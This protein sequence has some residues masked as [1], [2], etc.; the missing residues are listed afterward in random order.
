MG[1]KVPHTYFTKE[2]DQI[3]LAMAAK[4]AT[5][6]EIAKVL[7]RSLRSV[8]SRKYKLRT[9]GVSVPWAPKTRKS[10]RKPA[11]VV[12]ETEKP[13]LAQMC[14]SEPE[15]D[16]VAPDPVGHIDPIALISAKIDAL[17][18]QE[19]DLMKSLDRVREERAQIF[20]QLSALMEAA[21]SAVGKYEEVVI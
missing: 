7:N 4:R 8:E 9:D 19:E 2:D 10:N 3:L 13:E 21:L 5:N 18:D 16:P 6:E 14:I 12:P 11:A 17:N 20:N 15:P 1:T